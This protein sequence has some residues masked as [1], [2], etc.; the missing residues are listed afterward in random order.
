MLELTGLTIIECVCFFDNAL[1][2]TSLICMLIAWANV[3]LRWLLINIITIEVINLAF[4]DY[5]R[6][7][8]LLDG[9][10]FFIWAVAINILFIFFLTFRKY[11]AY[12]IAMHKRNILGSLFRKAYF[13]HLITKN[14]LAVIGI[15]CIASMFSV[16]T[17]I[18]GQL[19][20]YFIIDSTPLRDYLYQP[21]SFLLQVML[22]VNVIRNTNSLIKR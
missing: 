12:I 15:Y 19:Y 13:R 7:S 14:E 4:S 5:F 6:A 11:T 9:D 10:I 2:I 20:T 16:T 3:N 17:G 8:T 22:V 21:L 1:L 18:E